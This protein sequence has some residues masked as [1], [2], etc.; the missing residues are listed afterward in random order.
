MIETIE[1]IIAAMAF[2]AGVSIIVL[3]QDVA[4]K[5]DIIKPKG[6]GYLTFL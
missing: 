3:A 2:I 6:D 5:S 1:I 4:E